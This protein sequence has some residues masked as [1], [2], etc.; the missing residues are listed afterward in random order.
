MALDRNVADLVAQRGVLDQLSSAVLAAAG[1][2]LV[3]A[4]ARENSAA[5]VVDQLPPALAKRVTAG[6]LGEGAIAA[7]DC[8]QAPETAL[9]ASKAR[10]SLAGS[11]DISEVERGEA[12]GDATQ[13][14]QELERNNDRLRQRDVRRE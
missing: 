11:R 14:R 7:S 12:T 3:A 10:P 8:M 6:L 5:S 1:Q 2:A 9:S 4:W 13:Y